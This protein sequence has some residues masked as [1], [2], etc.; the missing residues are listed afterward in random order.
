MTDKTIPKYK[1]IAETIQK[2]I[3]IG[4]YPVGSLLPPESSLQ[5]SFGVSCATIRSAMKMLQKEGIVSIKQGRGTRVLKNSVLKEFNSST[6]LFESTIFSDKEE[7]MSSEVL[8]V[9]EAIIPSQEDADFLRIPA[10]SLVYR[11]QRLFKV[12]DIPYSYYVDY[13]PKHLV[14]N[15]PNYSNEFIDLFYFFKLQYGISFTNATE[16]ITAKA[17]DGKEARMLCVPE[18]T[19]LLYLHRKAN[20]DKGPLECGYQSLRTDIYKFQ[21]LIESND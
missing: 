16:D 7:T 19:P 18:E 1:A 14:P 10:G 11:V 2:E 4:K 13:I 9:D 15:L 6:S 3:Y 12:N 21:V 5:K 17:A 20:C 8:C